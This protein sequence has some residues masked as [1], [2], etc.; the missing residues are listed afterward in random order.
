MVHYKLHP[1]LRKLDEYHDQAAHDFIF[2][3]FIYSQKEERIIINLI[4]YEEKK[5]Y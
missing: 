4:H 2:T 3:Q 1:I 5:L